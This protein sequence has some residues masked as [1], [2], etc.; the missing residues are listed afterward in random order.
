MIER[1]IAGSIITIS[2]QVGVVGGPLR[3]IYASAKA[4]SAR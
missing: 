3:A 4:R 2:S 1:E